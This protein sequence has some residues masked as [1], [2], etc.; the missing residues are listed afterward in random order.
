MIGLKYLE[1]VVWSLENRGGM[2]IFDELL[3]DMTASRSALD[4]M[5]DKKLRALLEYVVQYV[6]F[7]RQENLQRAVQQM[8]PQ[9]AL[10]K[11]PTLSK[12]DIQKLG[13]K[14]WSPRKANAKEN[15]SGG[16]TGYILDFYQNASHHKHAVASRRLGSWLSGWRPGVPVVYFWGDPAEMSGVRKN[17][18]KRLR[19]S[20]YQIRLYNAFSPTAEIFEKVCAE[21]ERQPALLVGYASSLG[22]L[23][24]YLKSQGR[25]IK[26]LGVQ[27]TADT[28]FDDLRLQLEE[29]FET[30]VYNRYG[31]RELS[32]IAHELQGEAGLCVLERNNFVEILDG[33]GRDCEPGVVGKMVVTNLNN[34]AMP[35]IRYELGDIGCWQ[36]PDSQS[37]TQLRRIQKIV[38]RENDL[39]LGPSGTAIYCEFFARLFYSTAGV[40]QFQLIQ[41]ARDHLNIKIVAEASADRA[42]LERHLQSAITKHAD[43]GFSMTFNYFDEIPT[44]PS[45]K[46]RYVYRTW[47]EA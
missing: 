2:S 37:K 34:D 14:L 28:L 15:H 39:I 47:S 30:K 9:D 24:K 46:R 11:F 22:L 45:G 20:I 8:A 25:K 5:V 27:A 35:F 21:L 32:V 18:L 23:A 41:D 38:G 44:V 42:K 43:R 1:P 19:D 31:S 29:T 26:T 10:K 12:S 13:A 33:E 6:P 17:G 4:A 3:S 16:S 36:A 40:K 7:Y